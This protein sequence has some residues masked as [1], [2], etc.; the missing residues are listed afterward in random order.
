VRPWGLLGHGPSSTQGR[1]LSWQVMRPNHL[2]GWS[3][4]RAGRY[5][6]VPVAVRGMG[7][8]A[9]VTQCRGDGTAFR[10]RLSR[11][12]DARWLLAGPRRCN[13]Q[14]CAN[15]QALTRIPSCRGFWRGVILEPKH[16]PS[17]PLTPVRRT[18]SR[19]RRPAGVLGAQTRR[20]VAMVTLGVSEEPSVE[21]QLAAHILSTIDLVRIA[22]GEPYSPKAKQLMLALHAEL[23][24]VKSPRH[25]WA[26][27]LLEEIEDAKLQLLTSQDAHANEASAATPSVTF[28][29]KRPQP[30]EDKHITM[31][32][33][34]VAHETVPGRAVINYVRTHAN[35]LL[36]AL[37]PQYVY[38]T[39]PTDPI[40]RSEAILMRSRLRLASM[41]GPLQLPEF[42][43]DALLVRW[44][45]LRTGFAG[46][47]G[48]DA[49]KRTTM[50]SWLQDPHLLA[51]QI[52]DYARRH[53]RRSGQGRGGLN[54]AGPS[55]SPKRG[56]APPRLTP[57]LARAGNKRPDRHACRA[58]AKVSTC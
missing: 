36:C 14:G 45:F 56:I 50:L 2:P 16:E 27:V 10:T 47:G 13:R 26:A 11:R 3:L 18:Q 9:E 20:G 4:L 29:R 25:H 32:L 7:G 37:G 41:D 12:R 55:C 22:Y 44:L 8:S 46:G 53:R 35:S 52:G 33:E 17:A 39:D 28:T 19:N 51:A 6:T 38:P 23:Y 48:P 24:G 58:P 34:A 54:R 31:Q 1:L 15:W 21:V 42:A 30:G 43:D 49:V 40:E 57:G 5:W